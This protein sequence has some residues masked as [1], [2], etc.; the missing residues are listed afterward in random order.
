[1]H[2]IL[3]ALALFLTT[4][5]AVTQPATLRVPPET[6]P[7]CE[8]MCAGLD[9]EL[10]AVVV[11]AN[12]AGCVCVP[13]GGSPGAKAAGTAAGMVVLQQAAQQQQQQQQQQQ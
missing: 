12:S 4:A 6:R 1:M 13:A 10:G 2:R 8:N 7:N 5:C 3:I 11:I 9:M